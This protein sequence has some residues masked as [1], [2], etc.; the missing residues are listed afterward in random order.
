MK[1]ELEARDCWCPVYGITSVT[2]SD[3][4]KLHV[5]NESKCIGSKCMWWQWTK[6]MI[7]GLDSYVS[8][9]GPTGFCGAAPGIVSRETS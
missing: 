4:N 6:P 1:T 9:P 8:E 5:F 2:Y 3:D 7:N